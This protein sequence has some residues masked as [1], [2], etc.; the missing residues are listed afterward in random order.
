MCSEKRPLLLV[1]QKT[2]TK[3]TRRSACQRPH[4]A[5]QAEPPA[6]VMSATSQ[7]TVTGQRAVGFE[8]RAITSSVVHSALAV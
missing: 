3:C 1:G 6:K 2:R 5:R 4:F 8:S 7:C